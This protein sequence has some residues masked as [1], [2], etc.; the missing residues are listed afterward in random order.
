MSD[1]VVTAVASVA[2]APAAPATPE[3]VVAPPT[4]NAAKPETPKNWKNIALVFAG[5]VFIAWLLSKKKDAQKKGDVENHYRHYG[6][7]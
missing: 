6:D 3:V 1:P 2:A 4:P 5:L 7:F